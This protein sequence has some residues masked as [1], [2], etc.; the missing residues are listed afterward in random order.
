MAPPQKKWYDKVADAIL[1]DDDH[2]VGS[3]SSRYALICERCFTHN[4]L[5]K[6]SMWEDTRKLAPL[7]KSSLLIFNANLEFICRNPNCKHFNPSFRSKRQVL[8]ANSP[9]RSPTSSPPN[10]DSQTMP[11]TTPPPQQPPSTLNDSR[12]DTLDADAP[13]VDPVDV[14]VMEVDS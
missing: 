8:S 7:K 10:R 13:T 12:G 6:E 5:V 11:S 3:P 1:G 9:P 14:G 4:G 2:D